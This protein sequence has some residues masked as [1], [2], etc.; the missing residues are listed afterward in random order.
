MPNI[1]FKHK[2][3]LLISQNKNVK[4]PKSFNVG[5]ID[6]FCYVWGFGN[7][8]MFTFYVHLQ[9]QQFEKKLENF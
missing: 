9:K 8:R 7:L 4:W 3:H 5:R 2:K 1:I 6:F